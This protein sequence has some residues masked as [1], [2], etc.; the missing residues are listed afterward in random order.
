MN[1][2]ADAATVI[3]AAE[4]NPTPRARNAPEKR[5]TSTR[6]QSAGKIHE[7]AAARRIEKV[8]VGGD[9]KRPRELS[10]TELKASPPEPQEE[11]VGS[12]YRTGIPRQKSPARS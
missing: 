7:H 6:E 9:S 1:R 5:C 2:K 11:T 4:A 3:F 8:P 12:I 10:C